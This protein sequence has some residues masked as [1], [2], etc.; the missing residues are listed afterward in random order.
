[1]GARQ[2]VDRY[3]NRSRERLRFRP[4]GYSGGPYPAWVRA[5]DGQSGVYVIREHEARGPRIVYVGESGGDR[6]Y[7]T[8]TR[9]FQSWSRKGRVYQKYSE[10]DPGLTYQRERCD[11]ATIITP[12]DRAYDIQIA[13]IQWLRP[14][15]NLIGQPDDSA[16]DSNDED[17]LAPSFVDDDEPIPF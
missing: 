8:L 1:M 7:S 4:V 2:L 16:D 12:A 15:D 3:R 17:D 13:F 11:A 6:L 10:H 14:R 9:H 5:L